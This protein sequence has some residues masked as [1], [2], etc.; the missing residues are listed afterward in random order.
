MI[1]ILKTQN[2]CR[3]QSLWQR[4]AKLKTQKNGVT[5]VELLVYI[6]I[7]SILLLVITDIFV[8]ILSSRTES[9]A[10]SFVDQDGH[11]ILARLAYD[12]ARSSDITLP[13]ALGQ[14]KDSLRLIVN[15]ENFDYKVISGSLQLT[16]NSGTDNLNGNQTKMDS[17]SFTKLGNSG[18]KETVQIQMTISSITQRASGSETRAYQTTLG[19]R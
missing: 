8:A 17:I 4:S 16:N 5:L 15:G 13:A 14:T 10:T 2:L 3:R 19:R 18:G 12:V 6:G 7:L 9:E 11:S 1:R